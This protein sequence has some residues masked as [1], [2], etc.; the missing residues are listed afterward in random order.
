MTDLS[1]NNSERILH[2][3]LSKEAR[4][5]LPSLYKTWAEHSEIGAFVL[6]WP[7]RMVSF[8]GHRTI[9]PMPFDMPEN[10]KDWAGKL[11]QLIEDKHAFALLLVE[12]RK[13]DILAVFESPH[14]AVSWQVPIENHGDVRILG[15]PIEKVDA[16]YIGLLWSP[17]RATP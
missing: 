10:K 3:E 12:Q 9:N 5:G 11:R 1:Y 4:N 15:T 14:G 7:D 16:E 13:Q 2:N 8:H 6:V 17:R